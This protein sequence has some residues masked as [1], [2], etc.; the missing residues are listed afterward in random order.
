MSHPSY[1]CCR[2][3]QGRPRGAQRKVVATLGAFVLLTVATFAPSRVVAQ[4]LGAAAPTATTSSMPKGESRKDSTTSGS[5]FKRIPPV[6]ALQFWSGA[7]VATLTASD[8]E[9]IRGSMKIVGVQWTHDLFAWHGARVSWV[10]EV[11]PLM[12]VTSSSPPLR[13]PA[14]L[15]NPLTADP[16]RLAL[17]LEHDSYGFGISPLSA[18]AEIPISGHFSTIVQVTSGA[19][20]FSK[21]VPYGQATQANFTVNPSLAFQWRATSSARVAFGYTLHHLSNGSFGGSNPGMNSHMFLMRVMR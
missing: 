7:S 4:T 5:A 17:Y 10:T 6:N 8:N 18:Q 12:L 11:L 20:W 3:T 14:R 2:Q 1:G 19:A 15:R 21:V 16:K 13:I 9:Y